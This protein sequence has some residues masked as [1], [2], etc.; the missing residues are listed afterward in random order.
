MFNKPSI[1]KKLVITILLLGVGLLALPTTNALAAE[2][3]GQPEIPSNLVVTPARL[4]RTWTRLQRSYERQDERLA[5][6]ADFIGRVE[7]LIEKANNKGWD[8]SEVQAALDAFVQA[9]PAA[10]QAHEP[11]A[12]IIASHAGFDD[13]GMVIDRQAAFETT[14]SLR[15]VL[16][17]T[18][19]AMDGTSEE[20]RHAIR[21]LFEAYGEPLETLVKP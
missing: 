3:P 19:S 9:L 11:G 17:D 8:T 14:K 6:S 20:L 10:A 12:A 1:F 16:M 4:E 15:Q 21:D 2:P 18:R 5:K 7:T 13:N